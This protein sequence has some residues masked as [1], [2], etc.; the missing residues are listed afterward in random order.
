VRTRIIR[1]RN[2]KYHRYEPLDASPQV[3]DLLDY[4][5][6]RADPIFWGPTTG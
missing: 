2:Q 5:N 4:L 1:G 6:D 3:Q